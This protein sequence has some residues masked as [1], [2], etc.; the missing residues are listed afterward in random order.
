MVRRLVAGAALLALLFGTACTATTEDD[1]SS[2]SDGGGSSSDDSTPAG[3]GGES[4]FDYSGVATQGVTDDSITLGV[5][6]I[7]PSALA[8]LGV[9][10]VELAPTEA[11]YQAW[12]DD[13]N[14]SGGINGREVQL[15]FRPFVP[16]VDAEAEAA[17]TELVEDEQVFLA[18]GIFLDD[19]P[20]CFTETHEVPYLGLFSLS[21]E[22]EE[23]SV[24]PFFAVEMSDD[25]QKLGGVQQLAEAGTFDDQ[26]VA[27]VWDT[28][29]TP[30][31][32]DVIQPY[33][34]EQDVDVV[35]EATR[36]IVSGTDQA[37]SDQEL[38][39]M[40]ERISAA[41]PDLILNVSDFGALPV[42]LQRN[43]YLPEGGIF[44]TSAQG[45]SQDVVSNLALDDETLEAITISSIAT[46]ASEGDEAVRS[47]EGIQACL[48][49]Y[50]ASDPAEPVDVAQAPIEVLSS[51]AQSCAA[52]QI[53]V[54]AASAAGE[55]LTPATWAAGAE[56]LG[57]LDLPGLPYASLTPTQH[58]AGDAIATYSWDADE[59]RYVI[60]GEPVDVG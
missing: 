23:R 14:A 13:L 34:E 9:E 52:F 33:L 2:G 30:V 56:G 22:R 49:T 51:V 36:E 15:A 12:I 18:I 31:V 57:D 43:G 19:G 46:T 16:Y 7:D 58:S 44:S 6:N 1:E 20:L 11:L 38:D 27:L 5:A 59:G 54:E 37:A 24:A 50:D 4:S 47:D 32:E 42:A 53:F 40:V 41:D 45:L 3:E 55:D 48:D 10:G 29:D 28:G 35:V 60:D 21:P 39:V 25:R 8:E 26:A 17:C